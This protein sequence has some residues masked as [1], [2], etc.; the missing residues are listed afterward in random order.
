METKRY[1]PSDNQELTQKYLGEGKGIYGISC[2]AIIEKR[3]VNAILNEFEEK[4]GFKGYANVKQLRKYLE[5]KGYEVKF[6]NR[7]GWWKPAKGGIYIARIQWLG[8]GKKK[9]QP[10]YGWGHWTEATSHTH[11]ILIDNL[12][13]F[14][15]E[16]NVWQELDT[17]PNYLKEAKGIMT[18][19]LEVN[20]NG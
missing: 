6:V 17:L 4:F 7:N 19:F 15:N 2:L 12:K 13:F 5:S 14:C 20:R 16:A 9:K 10:F 11:F 18:S 8:E 3:K 1:I